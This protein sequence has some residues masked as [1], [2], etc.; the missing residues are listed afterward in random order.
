V[1]RFGRG[2]LRRRLLRLAGVGPVCL[3]F[4]LAV[5][6]VPG[7]AHAD[8]ADA[9]IDGVMDAQSPALPGVTASVSGS[10]GGWYGDSLQ[11]TFENTTNRT[12]RISIPIGTRFKPAD[13][14][15]QTM[16][17]AG[18]ETIVVPPGRSTVPFKAFCGERHDAPP[19]TSDQFTPD[20]KVSG[21]TL[22]ALTS[23]NE[24]D[25]HDSGTQSEVW[26]AVDA[27]AENDG[28]SD[29]GSAA[30]IG[31]VTGAATGAAAAAVARRGGG[32]GSIRPISGDSA[33]KR[34]IAAGYDTVEID[35]KT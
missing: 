13:E 8:G 18:N 3:L 2:V 17:T 24:A 29:A 20:G 30:V 11:V 15:V 31:A 28:R 25:Q 33:I 27:D 21:K 9:T 34:L 5:S 32:S 19:G 7:S 12:Y 35:G 22:D 16:L 10:G 1:P 6:L 14:G 23:A 4:V 26:D